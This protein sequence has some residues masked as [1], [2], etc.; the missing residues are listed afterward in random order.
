MLGTIRRKRDN[1]DW[2]L[3]FRN[4]MNYSNKINKNKEKKIKEN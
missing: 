1:P 3:A 2:I 4:I